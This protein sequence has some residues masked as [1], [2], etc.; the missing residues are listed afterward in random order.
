M[1]VAKILQTNPKIFS[2]S[3]IL[4]SKIFW[5]PKMFFKLHICTN[6]C[7]NYYIKQRKQPLIEFIAQPIC[8]KITLEWIKKI[9]GQVIQKVCFISKF[10]DFVV[11]SAISNRNIDLF[12][13]ITTRRG[14]AIMEDQR[15]KFYSNKSLNFVHSCIYFKLV[16]K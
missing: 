7:T 13:Y 4:V 3:E 12:D 11:M 15:L 16:S 6:I 1:S 10:A 8:T 5:N 2:I 14:K 9:S